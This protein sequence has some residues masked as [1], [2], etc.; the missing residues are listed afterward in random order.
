LACSRLRSLRSSFCCS[1]S[2]A[3]DVAEEKDEGWWAG[4]SDWGYW[5]WVWGI[6]CCK[7]C[8]TCDVGTTGCV[9]IGCALYTTLSGL[10]LF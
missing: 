4:M 10:D 6:T 8:M 1:V 9:T 5:Y 7:G 3:V 2:L